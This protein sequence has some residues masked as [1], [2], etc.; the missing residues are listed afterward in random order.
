[1]AFQIGENV[2]RYRIVEQLGQGGMATVYKAYHAELDR[3]VALKVLHPAFLEEASFLARFQREARV[4]AKLEHP[5]IVPIYDYAEHEGRPYLVMKFIEGE[6]LKARLGRGSI[7]ASEVVRIVEAVG[8]ALLYAHRRGILHRDIKPSN[9][10]LG[11]DGQIYLADFGL[12][13]IAQSGESTLTSD[14]IVG[15]PQYISP[16]QAMGK[17]DLDDGTDIY[18]F[19]VMLYELIVGRVPFN[20]DTPFSIIHDHIYSPLPL[21]SQLNVDVSPEVERVLLKALAKERNDRYKDVDALVTAFLEAWKEE[22]P[23]AARPPAPE[24]MTPT[25]VSKP[26]PTAVQTA[27]AARPAEAPPSAASAPPPPASVEAVTATPAAG[28]VR[29]V[30]WMWIAV[31]VLVFL[32]CLFTFLALRGNR[33][34]ISGQGAGAPAFEESLPSLVTPEV[35]ELLAT[36]VGWVEQNPEDPYAHLQLAT[37]YLEAGMP[38]KAAETL[39][40]ALEVGGQNEAFLWDA[41]RQMEVHQA[42]LSAARACVQGAE[43]HREVSIDLPPDLKTLLFSTLYRAAPD[44]ALEEFLPIGRLLLL[45]EM[46]AH[47]VKARHQLYTSGPSEALQTLE[48]ALQR[49]PDSPEIQLVEAE[50]L[51]RTDNAAQ[52]LQVLDELQ[53]RPDVPEWI[54]QEAEQIRRT[55][56]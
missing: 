6:T 36:A 2:G 46:I 54:L 14:M 42:W 11:K 21:P 8:A 9:V 45:D 20:A 41:C 29:K 55:I 34:T 44:P 53:N 23:I 31:A 56:P 19:G 35:A 52:A 24:A 51:V 10:L 22:S 33:Q 30:P 16:E 39:G 25:P 12:A 27:P 18:S 7:D 26:A 37:V 49:W 3:Y 43:A 50:F 32:C 17:K 4:V 15:T 5:N 13:R 1:M 28:R 40:R 47:V 48:S 38:E